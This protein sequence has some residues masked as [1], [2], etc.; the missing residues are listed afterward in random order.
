VPRSSLVNRLRHAASTR[1]VT[2][3]A[4][5]G[6]GKTTL[7]AQWAATEPRPVAWISI[8]ARDN[9]PLV[10]LRHVVTALGRVGPQDPQL[11][12][13]LDAPTKAAWHGVVERC[14][15]A[16]ASTDRPYLLVLDNAD[17]IHT[18]E[19]RRVL[20][21]LVARIPPGSTVAIGAR[22]RPKLRS[23]P[24]RAL[25]ALDDIGVDELALNSR[26][27]HLLIQ[28]TNP[29]L[30]ASETADLVKIC[31]GWPAALYL[32]SL[33]LRDGTA[34]SLRPTQ[35]GGSDRYLADYLRAQC[36]A[37]LRP[38]E[39]RFLRRTAVL[40][41]LSAPLCDA[42]LQE[43]GSELELER[44]ARA[45]LFLVRLER[46]GDWF[47]F[48]LLFRDLLLRELAREEP[49]LIPTLHRRAADWYE[50]RGQLDAALEHADAA[51]DADR[52]ASIICA[53]AF[54]ISCRGRT[55]AVEQW[56]DRFDAATAERYPKL[57]VH[58]SR[59]FALRGRT[60]DAERWLDAA[61][62]GAR[63]HRRDA[64]ALR[65]MTAVVRA[66]LC[67]TGARQMAADADS[68]LLTLRRK[69]VWRPTALLVRG[70]AALLAGSDEEADV[71]LRDA[72]RE[73]GALGCNETQ[74]IAISQRSF[75]A[76][77]RGEPT[78]A[79]EL[80]ADARAVSVE[81]D[82]ENY[83]TFAAALTA[84]AQTALRHGKW[85]EARDLLRA[86]EPG[87]A[88]L[89]EATPWLA[90]GV[91]LEIARCYLTL[92]D[93]DAARALAA[94][95]ELLLALRPDLGVLGERTRDLQRDITTLTAVEENARL[96]LTPAE[97]RLIPLLATHLSFGEIAEQ[98]SISRNTVKTQAIS[99][100]RKFGVSGRSDAIAA[101]ARLDPTRAAA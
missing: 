24:L 22:V 52:V 9:D 54:P 21:A 28:A 47:R 93:L 19:A 37:G 101:A 73:A 86:T 57:A 46:D 8:D 82:L 35:F 83:S 15:A 7:L 100:Y 65:L 36:L 53:I 95:I 60:T 5:A 45:N 85:A 12:A 23:A 10:F 26:E 50:A 49:H 66:S 31:D 30:G 55:K 29:E 77:R 11:I 87:R 48:H 84:S 64:P 99:I 81:N 2:V 97:L 33:S 42:V 70:S 75:I 34:A 1:A 76:R 94:E 25:G 38:R 74:M 32:A 59:I 61:E 41:A 40:G 6:Y 20:S 69:S 18:Q 17:L 89:T 79:D 43:E 39:L 88:F 71:V 4:P 92:R 58:G 51:G 16:T 63:R 44:I 62:R 67:R 68:A 3:V 80:S 56:L 13:S 91:R 27:A 96:G 90:V 78:L 72:A 98:L 14:L